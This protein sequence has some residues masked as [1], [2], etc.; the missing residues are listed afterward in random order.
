MS[1][2][3]VNDYACDSDDSEEVPTLEYLLTSLRFWASTFSVALVALT[4]LLS[5]FACVSPKLAQRCSNSS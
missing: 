5:I 1:I 4:A 2:E 3:T